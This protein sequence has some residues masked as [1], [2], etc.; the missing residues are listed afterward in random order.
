MLLISDGYLV[1]GHDET[2][3]RNSYHKSEEK[4]NKT[5]HTH[6]HEEDCE[7]RHEPLKS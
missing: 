6:T 3:Y 2:K 1:E 7:N 4:T 5:K